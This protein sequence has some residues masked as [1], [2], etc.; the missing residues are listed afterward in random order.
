LQELLVGPASQT[1]HE[2]IN[3]ST[4]MTYGVSLVVLI[5]GGLYV[6]RVLL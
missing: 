5:L 3:Y 4:T 1:Q 2:D 6:S